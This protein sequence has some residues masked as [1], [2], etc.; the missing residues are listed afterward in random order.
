[1]QTTS[2]VSNPDL[3][4]K[5][6]CKTFLYQV[7]LVV[8]AYRLARFLHRHQAVI[9]TYHGVLENRDDLYTNR[10]CIDATIFDRQ[11]AFLAHSYNVVPLSSLVQWLSAG[12]KLPPYTAVITFDDG[13]RNN[14]TVALPILKK[15]GLPATIFLATSF[16]DSSD[17]GLWTEQIGWLIHRAQGGC[18]SIPVDGAEKSFTLGTKADREFASDRIRAYLKQL[19]PKRRKS[20]ITR[21]AEQLGVRELRKVKSNPVA[22]QESEFDEQTTAK[23][24]D[25]RYAFLTWQQ[26]LAM[27]GQQ[28]VFGSH[29][30]T[31]PILATLTAEEASFEVN[32]SRRLIEEK[33]NVACRVFSYPNGTE[34][35]FGTRE[36]ELLHEA[37]YIAAVT[38]ID[39]FNDAETDLMALRRINIV[40]SEDFSFFLAKISGVWSLL[41]YFRKRSQISSGQRA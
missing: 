19:A 4:I 30:H 34:V 24:I 13:L 41:K 1:V 27:A 37:G 2:L 11:M 7:L 38:Q 15:Y 6:G 39:G 23:K 16:I 33:L 22:S 9:L 14:F 12:Q 26:I 35:D 18:I 8:G 28:I 25:E 29:T 3:S 21:L 32:E 40:H 36:H 17:L 5:T 20:V 10:N 31:H